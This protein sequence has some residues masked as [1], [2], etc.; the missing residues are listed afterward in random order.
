M[1]REQVAGLFTC[2]LAA[3]ESLYSLEIYEK[4]LIQLLSNFLATKLSLT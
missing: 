1:K 2:S 4:Q 3:F